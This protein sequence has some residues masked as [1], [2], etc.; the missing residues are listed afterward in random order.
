M[1]TSGHAGVQ[2]RRFFQNRRRQGAFRVAAA[3]VVVVIGFKMIPAAPKPSGGGAVPVSAEKVA[4]QN[5]P[6]YRY[7]YGT[8]RAFNSV[9]LKVRVDG[10]LD[11]VLFREGQNVTAGEMLAQIDPR[12]YQAALNQA[13]ARK[14]QDEAQLVKARADLVRFDALVR[15]QFESQQ[16]FEAQQSSV[17]QL[18][19]AIKSDDAMIENARVQLSYT[20]ITAPVS[21]RIGLRQVD[22]GNILHAAD[23][24]GL[25]VISEVHPI[26]AI[27]NLPSSDLPALTKAGIGNPL[28]VV[29]Y[30]SDDKE[31]LAEGELLTVDNAVDEST[32]TIKLKATFPNLDDRLWPGQSITA[33]LLLGTREN[34]L[35]VPARSVQRG[36]AGLFVYV[37]QKDS[38][39]TVQPIET[40]DT[41]GD[42]VV[43]VSASL[44]EGDMVVTNGQSRLM[45][46]AKVAMRDDAKSDAKSDTKPEAAKAGER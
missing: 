35:T 15:K 24:V 31:K 6:Q 3:A 10:A 17:A 32:G 13:I 30:S 42:L 27:F 1:D 20:S 8:V 44:K 46:G 19:A 23:Q 25:A 16:N 40:S 22:M 14:A 21:G 37:V 2:Y 33:H 9:V 11:K 28:P 34:T 45:P 26:A 12:P 38:T 36:P 41:F 39:V 7:G 5:M 4:R 43:V 18:E 29:A